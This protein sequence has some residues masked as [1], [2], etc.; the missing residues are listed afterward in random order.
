MNYKVKSSFAS[1]KGTRALIKNKTK[2]LPKL[3]YRRPLLKRK[4]K[5][6]T[7]IDKTL[8]IAPTF[9]DTVKVKLNFLYTKIRGWY[10]VGHK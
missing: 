9:L 6:M 7:N 3:A 10:G 1:F 5:N 8:G 4:I 2:K